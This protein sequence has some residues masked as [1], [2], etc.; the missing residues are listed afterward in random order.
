MVDCG[1]GAQRPRGG[2]RWC[3]GP[4]SLGRRHRKR[5]ADRDR[6]PLWIAARGRALGVG[7]VSRSDAKPRPPIARRRGRQLGAWRD[8]VRG[9]PLRACRGRAAGTDFRRAVGGRLM[10]LGWGS[11]LA[12]AV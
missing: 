10:I 7:D 12:Y 9:R 4:A 2:D 5:T 3:R 6:G 11:L 8:T 1:G